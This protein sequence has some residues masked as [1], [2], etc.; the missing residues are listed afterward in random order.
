M[1]LLGPWPDAQDLL[2][3][4]LIRGAI[5]ILPLAEAD[6]PRMRELM[7]KYRDRPMDLADAGLVRAPERERLVTVF[8]TDR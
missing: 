2:W 4:M 5:R 3:Q 7:R 6:Y 8:T 1:Y